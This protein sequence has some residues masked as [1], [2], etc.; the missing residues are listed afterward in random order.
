MAQFRHIMQSLKLYTT[1]L[2]MLL[3]FAACNHERNEAMLL[4]LQ[5]LDNVLDDDPEAIKDSLLQINPTDLSQNNRAY[6]N[7]LKI[8]AGDKTYFDFTSDSLINDV[9]K[10]LHRHQTGSE[11]HIRS[12]IYQGVVRYRMGVTDSTAFLPLK[13]AE[14]LYANLKPAN[15]KIGYMMYYYLG[16]ILEKNDNDKHAVDYYKKALQIAEVEKNML[17][18]FDCAL[19]LFWNHMKIKDQINVEHYLKKLEEHPDKSIDEEYFFLNA[20][21]AYFHSQNRYEEALEINKKQVRLAQQIREDPEIFK[22]YHSISHDYLN[23]NQLDSALLYIEKS[24]N[25]IVDSNYVLNY[26]IYEKAAQ[27]SEAQN[28]YI[29]ANDYRKK[30]MDFRNISVAQETNTTILEL[31]KKYNHAEAEKRVI[32]EKAKNRFYILL[33]LILLIL[34]GTLINYLKQKKNRNKLILNSVNKEK[35]AQELKSKLLEHEAEKLRIEYEKKEMTNELYNQILNQFFNLENELRK[36]GDKS[37]ISNP[38]FSEKI[39]KLRKTMSKNL[40]ESFAKKITH[41]QFTTLTGTSLPDNITNPELLM[42]FLITCNLTNKELAI[43]FR[44]TLSSI[45]SR[46]HLLKNKMIELG[47]DT[48]FF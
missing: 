2:L 21:S 13:E 3:L 8:I 11:L 42:L 31:E 9:E 43:V 35:E 4:R 24:I 30:A 28:N 45:R 19:T 6:Y 39:E 26:L 20:L 34:L 46:K 1:I 48:S 15:L 32:K 40:I 12:L 38:D 37:K 44:T 27:I 36:I 17:H 5:Q 33:V 14:K 23:L 29:V 7:L 47:A 25:N 18:I 22:L 41:K 10:Q 16:K